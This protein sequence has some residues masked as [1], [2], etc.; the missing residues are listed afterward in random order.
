MKICKDCK[1]NLSNYCIAFNTYTD[2]LGEMD[3]CTKYKKIKETKTNSIKNKSIKQEKRLAKD[4]GAKRTPQSGAQDTAPSD[5]IVGNYI[6]ESKA[7]KGKSIN[8]K[9]EWLSSLKY[10]PMHL[11]QIPT[12]IL[13]FQKKSRY[14]VLAEEDFKKI[15]GE[16]NG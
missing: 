6:I 2:S 3:I 1:N 14:V 11:G 7:T 16:N 10:S 5:M 15:I 13:E 9:E 4:L 8:V 12:L